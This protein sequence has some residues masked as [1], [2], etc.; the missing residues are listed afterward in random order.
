MF[1]LLLESAGRKPA[2]HYPA[3]DTRA[4]RRTRRMQRMSAKLAA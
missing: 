4:W 1:T 2:R 3:Q